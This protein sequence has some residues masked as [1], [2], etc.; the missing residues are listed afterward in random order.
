MTC[1]TLVDLVVRVLESAMAI[2]LSVEGGVKSL[3]YGTATG[4]V[5]QSLGGTIAL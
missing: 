3:D 2:S 4:H 5:C 1:L